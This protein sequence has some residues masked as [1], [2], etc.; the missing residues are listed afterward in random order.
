MPRRFVE[1]MRRCFYVKE[2]FA[3]MLAAVWKSTSALGAQFF[4]KSFLGDGVAALA[5]SSGEG[6]A[7]PRHRADIMKMAWRTTER[8]VKL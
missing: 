1:Y 4:T 3:K 6:R 5:P 2:K 7:P 8:A